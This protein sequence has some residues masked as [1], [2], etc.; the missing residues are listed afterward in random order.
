MFTAALFALAKIKMYP[1]CSH[2]IDEW[3]S[4]FVCVCVC[5]CIHTYNGILLIKKNKILQFVATWMDLEGFMLS[6]IG[7]T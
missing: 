5:V 4:M 3:I 1:K 7:K 6:K 2:Q